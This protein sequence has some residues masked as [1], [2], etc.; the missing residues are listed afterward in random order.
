MAKT[1]QASTFELIIIRDRAN[2]T[3]ISFNYGN[4][5]IASHSE[6]LVMSLF[7][8]CCQGIMMSS[9]CV[10]I[11]LSQLSCYIIVVYM[12]S[13]YIAVCRQKAECWIA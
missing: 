13:T 12:G 5:G 1:K 6:S 8:D 2:D 10:A 4:L 7:L 9:H 11:V 3:T